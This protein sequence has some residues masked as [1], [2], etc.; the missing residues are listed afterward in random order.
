MSSR[1]DALLDDS[2]EDAGTSHDDLGDR[3]AASLQSRIQPDVGMFFRPVSVKFLADLFRKKP[4]TIERRLRRCNVVKWETHKGRPSPRYDFHEALG[5]LVDPKIDVEEWIKSQRIE[6]L[7]KHISDQF[8]KAM[9]SKQIYEREAG[10]LWHTDDVLEVFGEL[11]MLIN[12]T[13][14]LWIENIPGRNELTNDQYTA[15]SNSVD[16]LRA[17]IHE[18]WKGLAQ[19]RSTPS[20]I[21]AADRETA[22]QDE[23]LS[24]KASEAAGEQ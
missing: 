7:P 1:I 8:W 17:E 19:S 2:D 4:E 13:M 5:W 22:A 15:L 21:A 14:R 20:S 24:E 16:G 12:E 10:E 11:A 23:A 9:R 6:D 18:K 3:L